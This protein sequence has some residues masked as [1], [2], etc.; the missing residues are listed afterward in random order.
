VSGI[1]FRSISLPI[2]QPAEDKISGTSTLLSP[3]KTEHNATKRST[4]LSLSRDPEANGA[5]TTAFPAPLS[6]DGGTIAGKLVYP[7]L[8]YIYVIHSDLWYSSVRLR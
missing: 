3:A 8:P 5:A 7:F 2:Y 1:L 6:Y 4:F